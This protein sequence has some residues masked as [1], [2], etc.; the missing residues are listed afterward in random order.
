MYGSQGYLL[1][2][3]SLSRIPRFI[4]MIGFVQFP[5]VGKQNITITDDHYPLSQPSAKFLS[6][7]QASGM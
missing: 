5:H 4:Q 6:Q 3:L 2:F 1:E 7:Q